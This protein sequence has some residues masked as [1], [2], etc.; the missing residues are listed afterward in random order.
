MT[1]RIDE[2]AVKTKGRRAALGLALILAAGCQSSST[3]SAKLQSLALAPGPAYLAVGGSQQLTA[4]GRYSD[5]R[6]AAV[7]SGLQWRSSDAAIATVS[8]AGVVT[9]VGKGSAT[10]TATH[11]SGVSATAELVSRVMTSLALGTDLPRTGSVDTTRALYRV[12]G[13]TPGAFYL[14][15]LTKLDDDVD[16][17]VYSDASLSEGALACASQT[18]GTVPESCT[19]PASAAG[20]LYLA[21]D[22]SWTEDGASFQVETGPAAP[23]THADLAFP[24]QLPAAGTVDRG[25]KD[26]RVTGLTPGA[27]YVVRISGLSDDA[28]LDV[29]SDAYHYTTA[30][31]SYASGKV[32]DFCTAVATAAGELFVEVDGESTSSGASFTLSVTAA[33]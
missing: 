19:A 6:V 20:E 8:D 11:A 18:A 21:V 29:Y 30:C 3:P 22:G 25:E 33:R 16:L 26:Y 23:L 14:A 27:S 7:A 10:I 24:A 1:T 9:A 15:A 31:S 2:I 28:D 4:T 32:D 12:T 13:L 5:G 17:E